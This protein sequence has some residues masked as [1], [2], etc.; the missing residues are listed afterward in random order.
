MQAK[1]WRELADEFDAWAHTGEVPTLWWR[2][3]DAVEDSVQ[4]QRLLQVA[5]ACPISLAV[6]P[7]QVTAQLAECTAMIPN[8]AVLQHGWSHANHAATPPPS[9]YPGNRV[10]A[11]VRAELAEGRRRLMALFGN[12]V[13]PVFVPPFHGFA[14]RFLPL[15]PETGLSVISRIGP[16]ARQ[17]FP[18]GLT[19]ANVHVALRNWSGNCFCGAE[20]VLAPVLQ[21]LRRRRL[22]QVD[23]KEPTG[24][25]S[26]H[27][28]EDEGAYEFMARLMSESGSTP[29]ARW[30]SGPE[31]FFT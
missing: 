6:I 21:H 22:G 14:N 25:V 27:L 12:R 13:F 29:G 7:A 9:E 30:L 31:L 26:H 3:D 5:G 24:I 4:L 11:A 1:V 16:R 15:L 19:E 18:D 20:A 23:R 17:R 2:D 8:L 28:V 10:M